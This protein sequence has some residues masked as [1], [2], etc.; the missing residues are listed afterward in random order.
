MLCIRQKFYPFIGNFIFRVRRI[1]I[2]A[3]WNLLDLLSIYVV[4]FCMERERFIGKC[5]LVGVLGWGRWE[6]E[7]RL[8]VIVMKFCG[9]V[10]ARGR[11]ILEVRNFSGPRWSFL[12]VLEEKS[13]SKVFTVG[14][15]FHLFQICSL[16]N[17]KAPF[18]GTFN[19]KLLE[20]IT[21]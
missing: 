15:F 11:C 16:S 19:I 20:Q 6:S 9:E 17:T 3:K 7:S 1:K 5:R 8:K 14:Q 12:L 18:S 4:K 2:L 10:G 13:C 21:K